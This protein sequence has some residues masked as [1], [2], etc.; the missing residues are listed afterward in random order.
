MVSLLHDHEGDT[1]LVVLL[2]LDAGLAD[3]QQLMLKNLDLSKSR[4]L[5]DYQA[6]NKQKMITKRHQ[7]P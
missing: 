7:T 1:R 2:Q 4:G 5:K 6:K 3:R